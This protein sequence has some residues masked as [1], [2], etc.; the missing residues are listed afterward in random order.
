MI[1]S[2]SDMLNNGGGASGAGHLGDGVDGGCAVNRGNNMASLDRGNLLDGD[3]DINAMFGFDLSAGSFDGLGDRGRDGNGVVGEGSNASINDM[4]SI[5]ETS[6]GISLSF[7]LDNKTG[8][9]KMSAVF[10]DNLFASLLV[11]DFFADNIGGG[12]DIFGTRSARLD[13]NFFS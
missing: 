13:F 12:A 9:G 6:I 8:A 1:S 10:V 2:I 5:G 4:S 7:T 11:G 3:G